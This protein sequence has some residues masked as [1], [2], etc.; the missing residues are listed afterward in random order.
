[1]ATDIYEKLIATPQI[2]HGGLI[3]YHSGGICVTG[4]EVHPSSE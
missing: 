3:K 1:M 4:K 2:T